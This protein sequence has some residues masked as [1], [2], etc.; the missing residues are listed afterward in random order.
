VQ[1]NGADTITHGDPPAIPLDY[2]SPI[3]ERKRE[4]SS[5]D[6]R[7]AAIENYNQST[8]G[9]RRPFLRGPFIRWVFF[10]LILC[11]MAA[12]LPRWLFRWMAYVVVAIFLFCEHL[13]IR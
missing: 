9:E 2:S 10:A 4:R 8:F 11:L 6:Q 5:E 13:R 3:E 12:V 1:E 7:R